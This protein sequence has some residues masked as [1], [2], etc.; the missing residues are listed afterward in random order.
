MTSGCLLLLS[1][2]IGVYCVVWL[3]TIRRVQHY[4]QHA[5]WA[6]PVATFCGSCGLLWF[7]RQAKKAVF[8]TWWKQKT[9]FKWKGRRVGVEI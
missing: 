1:L 5:P 2:A 8:G 9:V 3:Q 7:V 6:V 4:E